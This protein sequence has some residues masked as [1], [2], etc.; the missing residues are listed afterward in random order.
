MH[1]VSLAL[2]EMN[3]LRLCPYQ[4][5]NNSFEVSIQDR[6]EWFN[7]TLPN[8]EEIIIYTDNSKT[9]EGTDEYTARS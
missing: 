7:N 6:S 2:Y 1:V 9:D 4:N 3:D 5:Y 8:E